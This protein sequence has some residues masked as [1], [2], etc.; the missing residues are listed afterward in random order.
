M[1]CQDR[2]VPL[3]A[4]L[5][6]AGRPPSGSRH[7]GSGLVGSAL[8]PANDTHPLL[9]AV[10]DHYYADDG[11]AAILDVRRSRLFTARDIRNPDRLGTAM[12]GQASAF[13]TMWREAER[14]VA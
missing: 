11:V 14:N 12:H 13:G 1:A 10:T 3:H 8:T 4:A 2:I 6:G 9:I 5:S 7:V